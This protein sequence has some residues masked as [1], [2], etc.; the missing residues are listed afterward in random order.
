MAVMKGDRNVQ[1]HNA[2]LN[3]QLPKV[4]NKK[5]TSGNGTDSGGS[6][7]GRTQDK[8]FSLVA[9]KNASCGRR[10]DKGGTHEGLIRI[11]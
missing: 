11:Y 3:C 7:S 4:R 8:H 9:S 5:Y 2:L 1:G 10:M 6:L